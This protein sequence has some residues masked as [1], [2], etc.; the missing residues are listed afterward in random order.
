MSTILRP[1]YPVRPLL[2]KNADQ[3]GLFGGIEPVKATAKAK[4]RQ[5]LYGGIAAPVVPKPKAAPKPMAVPG[6]KP[7]EGDTRTNR[8]GNKEVLRSGRWRLADNPQVVA[9]EPPA[10]IVPVV[11]DTPAQPKLQTKPQPMPENVQKLKEEK[12]KDKSKSNKPTKIVPV[13]EDIFAQPKPEPKP[14][15]MPKDDALEEPELKPK[16]AK[17]VETELKPVYDLKQETPQPEP[18]TKTEPSLD[19]DADYA[20]TKQ[21]S[22]RLQVNRQVK[23][24]L[25][26]NPD[27]PYSKEELTLLAKYSGKGGITDDEGSLSEYYT[28]PDVAKFIKNILSQFGFAGGTVLEPSCGNGVFLQQFKKD[29]NVLPVGVELDETSGAAAAALN[30]HAEVSGGQSFERFL[31]NN[32]DFS[33]DAVIGNVPFGTRTVEDLEA[34]R[35]VGTQWKDNGDFFVHESM[36]RM[37]PNG[38]MALVVPH[39]IT[40]GKNHRKLRDELIKQGRVLGV[41]RL[42]NTAFAHTGTKTITDILVMQKH[43]DAVLNA[44]AQGDQATINAMK[45]SDFVEG[46]Y[47]EGNPQHILGTVRETKN[48]FGG[49][50]FTVDGDIERSLQ[51]A[52]PFQPKIS[53]DGFQK[54]Q[55]DVP[56]AGDTRYINGRLYRLEGSPLRWHLVDESESVM[57]EDGIDT[58]A[59]GTDS[60]A[61]AEA[62][63]MDPG[64]RVTIPSGNL[65]SYLAIAKDRLHSAD[66]AYMRDAIAAANQTS[67]TMAKEKISHAMLLAGHVKLLQQNG[68]D[69]MGREQ[70]LAMLQAYREKYGNPA[71][72]KDLSKLTGQFSQLLQLQGAFDETDKISDYFANYDAISEQVTRS[73]GAAG[74]A[75]GEA[76][77]AAG[78]EMVNLETIKMHMNSNM[79]DADLEAALSSDSSVGYMGGGYMPIDRLLVGNGYN[80][81]DAMMMEAESL[82]E[83]SPLR[84]KLEEQIGVIRARLEPRAL[85]DMTTPFWAVGSWIPVNALN[86][87]MQDRGYNFEVQKNRKNEWFSI[88][89]S[90]GTAEDVVTVMNR[91]RISH[92]Q[93]TKEAKEAIEILQKDFAMWLAG[94][95]YRLEV[96]EAYNA[97]YTSELPQEFSGEPLEIALFDQHDGDEAQGVRKKRLHHYQTSTIR[98]MEEQGRGI[99]ALGVGLGKTATSIGLALRLKEI[100]RAKKPTF[101]VPKSVLSNWKREID[102]WAPNAN[103]MILGQTQQFWPDGS[104]KWQVPNP[105]KEKDFFKIET[106]GGMPKKDKDGNYILTNKNT[107]ERFT[108]TPDEISKKSELVFSDDDRATKERKMQQ[109]AQNTY[110]IVL[111]SEP[112]FQDIALNPNKES[113]Y[114]NDL[115]QSGSHINPDSQ[116][117]HKDKLRLETARRNLAERSLEKTEN[118]TF[119]TLGIDALFHDEA[120]HVKNLF[121]TQRSGDVAFLSQAQSNRALDFY[122]KSRYIREMNNNQNVYLLTA[123]PTTN[124]PLEAFNMLQHVA[125]EEFEKRGIESV[126]DFLGMFGKIETVM[127]P[128]TDLEMT[129]KNGLVG[130]QNLRDLRKLFNK[131]CRMQ[132][133]KDVGL[134]IPEEITYDHMVEM[135]DAQK[136]VYGDLKERAKE[137]SKGTDSKGEKTEDHIF[138]VISDMDKAAIDL[139]YYNSSASDRASRV[140][141]PEGELSPKITACV[142]NIMS[143]L[144]ANKGKQIVFCDAIQ[145]HG[146]IKEQ[147]VAAGY[148]A[149]QIQIVN[150]GTVPKAPDRLKVSNAFN[151]GRIT[152]VIG[153][154]ATMGEGMNFQI[155]TTDIHHLTT[156]WTPAAIEQ[157][158]GRGVRQGNELDGV[159]CHYYHA[160]GSFD[161][162]RKGVIERK[163]GWIDDLWKG[164][165]DQADNQ[166]TGALSMDEISVMMA[167]NP[168]EARQQMESNRELQMQRHQAKMTTAAMKQF[169]QLQTMGMAIA[170]MTPEAKGSARGRAL[171]ARYRAAK[172]ALSRN[173]YFQHKDLLDN[174]ANA[175]VGTDGTVLREGD[176][177]RSSDGSIYRINRVNNSNQKMDVTMV[178]GSDWTPG[179]V[180]SE[181]REF[182]FNDVNASEKRRSSVKPIAFSS[183]DHEERIMGTIGNMS[184]VAKLSPET[185]NANR[186]RIINIL[187]ENANWRNVPFV[188]PSTGRVDYQTGLKSMPENAQIL[189]PHD[190]NAIETVCKE[191]AQDLQPKWRYHGVIETLTGISYADKELRQKIETKVQGYRNQ[192]AAMT[193]QGPKDGDRKTEGGVEYELKNSRWHRVGGEGA[194]S[195][196]TMTEQPTVQT[197]QSTPMPEPRSPRSAASDE[198]PHPDP[199]GAIKD[200]ILSIERNDA[201]DRGMVRNDQGWSA[202]TRD[203]GRSLASHLQQGGDLTPNQYKRAWEMLTTKHRP[204]AG[205][206]ATTE[207]LQQA[208]N[209]LPAPSVRAELKQTVH[210]KKN[211]DLHVVALSDRVPRETY[212]RLNAQAKRLG[213]YFS[214]YN[215]QGAIPGFQFQDRD[216]AEEMMDYVYT[217]NK[218]AK[219]YTL[220][221]VPYRFDGTKLIKTSR[222]PIIMARLIS[223]AA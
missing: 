110:D 92:G 192:A 202:F 171:E 75:M 68:S 79:T 49:K 35:K 122:Y 33:P 135:T 184:D 191:M 211:I 48:Q 209:A 145:L 165:Q 11:E 59:L 87:F 10:A 63:L 186:D 195:A 72:D 170:K 99:I 160:K 198:G 161:A 14:E 65:L 54:P 212:D 60:M 27:G 148:P 217:L 134:P 190:G 123:T 5:K 188:D 32:P 125:P 18:E 158:N 8:A 91:G 156:P 74:D 182:K 61:Q 40:S 17:K 34:F 3:L 199:L 207:E 96:E 203:F 95:D 66:V 70:A 150:A 193:E 142:D 24:L 98:Q 175:Y 206:Q 138:S 41:Y 7:K 147:L 153:N 82:P 94:S 73:Y 215:K 86:E 28:R 56:K 64:R 39:G 151:A 181:P 166:N 126:D 220:L 149:D 21:Q 100:G 163:R 119:E 46:N 90:Y 194:E 143:S 157:R 208:I 185:I 189:W 69:D 141:M 176:H 205:R 50:S 221:G 57:T 81:M 2:R 47:F 132:S 187:K 204:Q 200:A 139:G 97:A 128:G 222:Q 77:R 22:E 6:K 1:L 29:N 144:T 83:G 37:K 177:I 214:S 102:F 146:Q 168:E 197:T 93:N 62:M 20:S 23:T 112:V 136:E 114:L 213:G 16:E 159:G 169:G 116:Q 107:G 52:Q 133:A 9:K 218:S 164:S 105:N 67:G 201:P 38:I 31:L 80:L 173:E 172:E 223:Y 183:Q 174:A 88:T 45:D 167:D 109:L 115:A 216:A 196:S 30:P 140:E 152:L 51:T 117:T 78:G 127:V 13:V 118:I 89:S 121:G 155:G 113:E 84:R 219:R 154:T 4:A 124:N 25:A 103:V 36:S 12:P 26:Q 120:H 85:E 162:Y 106:K 210:A 137:I 76:F 178:S 130:F 44:I 101:V 15:L 179:R 19:V 53:Y 55:E 180:D 42:P 58:S 108:M 71:M 111:M 104:P 131:Y 43:P 129:E